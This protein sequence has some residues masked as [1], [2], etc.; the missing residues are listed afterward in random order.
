MLDEFEN[1]LAL[2]PVAQ[3]PCVSLDIP[4]VVTHVLNGY[5]DHTAGILQL[6]NLSS[7]MGN[8]SLQFL[9][10]DDPALPIHDYVADPYGEYNKGNI[11]DGVE[12]LSQCPYHS[13]KMND[14]KEEIL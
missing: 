10:L 2:F 1:G 13:T 14:T 6:L 7:E 11:D 8:L 5:I 9:S 4:L 3:L 12:V